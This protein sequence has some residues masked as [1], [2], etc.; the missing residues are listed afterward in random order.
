MNR[1]EVI[2]RL[3]ASRPKLETLGVRRIFLFGSFAQNKAR[4]GSD[5]D[6]MIDLDEGGSG[7]KRLFSA[8]D[9]GAIQFALTEILGRKVDLAVRSDAMKLGGKLSAVAASGLVDVF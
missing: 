6:L 3:E 2:D 4:A 5:V 9:V 7:R 1:R 8:L